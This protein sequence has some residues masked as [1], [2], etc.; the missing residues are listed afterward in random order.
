MDKRHFGKLLTTFLLLRPRLEASAH[1][2]TGSRAQAEDILQDTWLKLDKAPSDVP[3]DNP[4]GYI[5]QVARNALTDQHRKERRRSEIDT[6][7]NEVLWE[8]SDAV[9]PERILIGREAIRAVE[10]VLDQLPERTRQIFLMNRIDGISH[11]KI[12][13]QF[14][15]SDEAVYYHIRRALERLASVRDEFGT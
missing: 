1:A 15:I 3:I 11:R 14:G 7:L 10:A 6:E 5:T 9:S 4:G 13:S 8:P 2:R 12:A